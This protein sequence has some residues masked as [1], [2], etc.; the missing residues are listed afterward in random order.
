MCGHHAIGASFETRDVT[1]QDFAKSVLQHISS[2][3]NQIGAERIDI[4]ADTYSPLGVK[5]PTIKNRGSET[6]PRLLFNI[7]NQNYPII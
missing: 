2:H 6:A 1:F 4:V 5:G 3:G 7:L